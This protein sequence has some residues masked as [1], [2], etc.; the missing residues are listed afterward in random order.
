M[1][2]R[3][4]VRF[5][6]SPTGA[7]HVGGARTAIYNWAFARRHGGVFVLRID[8]TDPE[9]STPE[10]TAQIMRSLRWLGLDWDEGPE[11][12][13][14]YGPY[15]QTQRTANYT[16]ALERMKAAGA[17]YPCFCSPEEL[18]A[19]RANVDPE[20]GGRGYDRTCRR[21]DPR[22][23]AERIAAGQPHAW[24]LAVPENRGEIIFDDAVRG[25]LVFSAEVMDDFVLVRA[26]GTPTYN[27]A[28]VVDDVDM[29][30]T[31]VIRGDDHLSNTP[32]QILVYEALQ[33]PIPVFAHLPMIWGP[34]GKKL[35]KRHGAASVEAFRDQ[36]F[37]PQALL[38][39]LALLGWSLDGETTIIPVEVLKSQFSLER[40]SK[41]PAI[42][43]Y[44]KLEWMNGVYIR[45]LPAETFVEH[46]FAWLARAGLAAEGDL[47]S[48][49]EW[50]L[51]LA[52]MVQERA[53]RLDQIP[54][55]VSYLFTDDIEL[56][57]QAVTQTLAKEGTTSMLAR[58]KETLASLDDWTPHSL[59]ATL[60]A[61]AEQ[62]GTKP[63]ILFQALRVAVTGTTVSLPLFESMSLLGRER[64]L[65]RLERAESIAALISSSERREES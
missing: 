41:N 43:D 60:R 58:A 27:F 35:S 55:L 8:D 37:L 17:A 29:H 54:A 25:H 1:P 57:P 9:R 51:A 53:K 10:N 20:E 30:I 59:D 26:D 13:G 34:D 4:R 28:T 14:P 49:R 15:F 40:I 22:V 65:K 42:F 23:V 47:E 52:P 64:T 45:E 5:A 32:R 6:P 19:K 39:Y 38:N 2:E 24:R 44:E 50:Y 16:A 63:R 7:L 31:H 3:V 11:V 62:L 48:R 12:G 36:G 56:D 21:L 61:L 33:A 18:E 46:M